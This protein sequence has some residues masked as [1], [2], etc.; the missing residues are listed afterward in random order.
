VV[1]GKPTVDHVLLA[2]VAQGIGGFAIDGE[3]FEHHSGEAVGG[4][5]DV[6]GDGHPDVLI[7]APMAAPAEQGRTYL[8]FGGDLSCT[9]R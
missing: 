1:Y 7:G 5:G 4:G 3:D 9:G 6:N 8:V 2:D